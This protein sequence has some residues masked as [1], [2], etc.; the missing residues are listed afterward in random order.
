MSTSPDWSKIFTG[1]RLG[2]EENTSTLRTEY[3]RDYDRIIFSSAFRR[4][5]NK[6]QVFPLPGHIF[7]HNRLT[8]SLEVASVGRSLAR[9]AGHYIA[10]HCID[11]SDH[12]S[13]EFYRFS[14]PSVIAS[15]C[16]AHDIGNPAFGHS[17]EKAISQ[18]FLQ[19][20]DLKNHFSDK[21]WADLI[22]F[23]GNAN[24][25]RIVA[26]R[27]PYR[28]QQGLGITMTTLAAMIKY[29]CES[30]AIDKTT[31]YR[32]KY[33]FFQSEVNLFEEVANATHMRFESR[34]PLV[35]ARHPFV[36]LVEAAD[37]ICYAI[38]DWEDAA[39]L[40]I[41]PHDYAA[42]YLLALVKTDPDYNASKT[43]KI[44]Q[45]LRSDPNEQLAYLRAKS[46]NALV[47]HCAEVFTHYVRSG[48]I[49]NNPRPLAK[50]VP[51]EVSDILKEIS[52]LSIQN[53]YNHDSVVKIELAG[54]RVLRGLL[55]DFV[56]AVLASEPNAAEEKLLQLL[57]I[58]YKPEYAD[59]AYQKVMKVLDFVSGM[60]DLYALELYRNLRGISM[61][62]YGLH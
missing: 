47:K 53:I 39:R 21:E 7:V 13:Q 20:Q 9:Y 31:A 50:K 48:E 16:L 8:H 40:K 3:E 11:A 43:E 46:I 14:L 42:E 26:Q 61:P 44:L 27:K 62:G 36:Y 15:A 41:L 55:E 25:F 49:F 30:V 22:N 57:P 17:G 12:S 5:Q 34:E 6:T 33:N 4:L 45:T 18:Y 24:A 60:T 2:D 28:I 19:N 37:D 32:K 38:M 51:T 1:R 35:Y 52:E 23:E 54:Y 59:T 10:Q 56:P 29:P 58:Q